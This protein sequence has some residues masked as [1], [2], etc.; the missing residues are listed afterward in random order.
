[1]KITLDKNIVEFTPENQQETASMESLW[2]VIID[3]VGE[4][5][6]LTPIG[7]YIPSKQNLVRFTLEGIPGGKTVLSEQV[8]TDACTYLCDVCN[9]YMNVKSGDAI[10]Y[11][12]GAVMEAID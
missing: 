10:P 1:M 9:K 7:E 6:K 4:S 12:C 3:C 8:S 11:C 2:R 5:K